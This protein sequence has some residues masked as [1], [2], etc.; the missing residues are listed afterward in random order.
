MLNKHGLSSGR[1]NGSTVLLAI[2]F[3]FA[4]ALSRL[5]SVGDGNK[6]R[7]VNAFPA[8]HEATILV[9]YAEGERIPA[10]PYLEENKCFLKCLNSTKIFRSLEL[11]ID[12]QV[13][14]IENIVQSIFM[15]F[16][17][18]PIIPIAIIISSLM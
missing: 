7:R 11:R 13:H 18:I 14:L 4:S 17:G 8:I 9:L 12:E 10:G 6:F 5:I 2:Q 3:T 1:H 15:Y 16:N